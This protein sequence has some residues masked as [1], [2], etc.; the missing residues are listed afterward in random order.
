MRMRVYLVNE[1]E[2][3]DVVWSRLD[4]LGTILPQLNGVIEKPENVTIIEFGSVK[5]YM[6]NDA[7][8]VNPTTVFHDHDTSTSLHLKVRGDFIV[9]PGGWGGGVRSF[10]SLCYTI[11]CNTVS[12]EHIFIQIPRYTTM[13]VQMRMKFAST[14][15]NLQ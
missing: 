6:F 2:E 5:V 14:C 4:V 10:D 3:P 11:R 7:V 1:L 8:Q 15:F 9:R 12:R 13:T